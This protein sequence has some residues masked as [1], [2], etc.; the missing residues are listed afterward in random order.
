MEV[1]GIGCSFLNFKKITLLNSKGL[2][3]NVGNL[4]VVLVIEHTVGVKP[5][6]FFFERCWGQ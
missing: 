3:H 4:G 1:L 6:F 2:I 5:F